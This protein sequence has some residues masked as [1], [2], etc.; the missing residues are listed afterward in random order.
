MRPILLYLFFL[1]PAFSARAQITN[2]DQ[3]LSPQ[4]APVTGPVKSVR[5]S[6]YHNLGDNVIK[7]DEKPLFDFSYD[8]AGHLV[9]QIF[10]E[11]DGHPYQRIAFEFDPENGKLL[12]RVEE[13]LDNNRK[14]IASYVSKDNYQVN[15]LDTAGQIRTIQVFQYD[16]KTR[17]RME[18]FRNPDL[19]LDWGVKEKLDERGNSVEHMEFFDEAEMKSEEH[20]ELIHQYQYNAAG[21][22]TEQL[23]L[24]DGEFVG[25]EVFIYDEQ[26]RIVETTFYY[27]R[28][29][30]L[31][32]HKTYRYNE[33]NDATERTWDNR[34]SYATFVQKLKYEY[35]YDHNGN[36]ILRKSFNEGYPAGTIERTITYW[37]K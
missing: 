2:T 32:F 34:E 35:V 27:E 15:Y 9:E 29:D 18:F 33:H 14:A 6:Q 12:K 25:K 7:Y 11:T 21:Q 3:I 26:G 13:D 17:I 20:Y 10:Y 19:S 37:E 1:L 24:D 23:S 31:S 16:P 28:P 30:R 8:E 36:W 5:I 22:I 4:N